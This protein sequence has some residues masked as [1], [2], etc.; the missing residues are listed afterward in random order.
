MYTQTLSNWTAEYTLEN[1]RN[2]MAL[3]FFGG[4][5]GHY[6]L[7]PGSNLQC[8]SHVFPSGETFVASSFT[9]QTMQIKL[10]GIFVGISTFLQNFFKKMH[11]LTIFND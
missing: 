4:F 10:S 5:H 2:V 9:L 7:Q 11:H 3:L 1:L 6:S 8:L